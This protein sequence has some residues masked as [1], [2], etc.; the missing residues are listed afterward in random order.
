MVGRRHRA[1]F[2]ATLWQYPGNGGWIFAT[3]PEKCAPPVTHAWGRT[4][5]VATVNAQ[6]WKTSVWHGKDGRTLLAVPK[7]IRGAKA[8]GDRVRVRLEFSL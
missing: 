4:P 3:V 8:A 2:L 5:V 7:K 6:T 1:T